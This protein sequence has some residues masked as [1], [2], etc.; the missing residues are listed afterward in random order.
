MSTSIVGAAIGETSIR[1]IFG[2]IN[3]SEVEKHGFIGNK[4]ND[5]GQTGENIESRS[6]CSMASLQP[7]STPVPMADITN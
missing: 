5:R 3:L 6:G 7:L 4:L 2:D 1:H